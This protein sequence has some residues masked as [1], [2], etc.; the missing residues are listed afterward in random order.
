LIGQGTS[1]WAA[2]VCDAYGVDAIGMNNVH[3]GKR[4]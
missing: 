3:H 4:C 1:V 2:T